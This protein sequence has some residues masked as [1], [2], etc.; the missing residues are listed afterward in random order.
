DGPLDMT[1]KQKQQRFRQLLVETGSPERASAA[2]ERIIN[3]ND[4][5]SINYL[6]KGTEASRPVCRIQLRDSS[7]GV[8][9]FG[10]GFLIGPGVLMTNHHVFGQA[11]EAKHSLADF[12]YELDL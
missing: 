1:P 3:G 11:S 8:I 9:G 7:G 2:L 4:L 10:S 6:S 5:D 12:D